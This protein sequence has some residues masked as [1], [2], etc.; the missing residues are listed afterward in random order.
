MESVQKKSFNVFNLIEGTESATMKGISSCRLLLIVST[1]FVV[2]VLGMTAG[3]IF[4]ATNK[5]TSEEVTNQNEGATKE[6]KCNYS[7]TSP[8]THTCPP[9]RECITTCPKTTCPTMSTLVPVAACPDGW[10][11]YSG[12]CY[13]F[14]KTGGSFTEARHYC[15][16]R[17]AYVVYIS[18]VNEDLFIKDQLLERTGRRWWVGITDEHIEGV[19]KS[20]NNVEPETEYRGWSSGEPNDLRGEDC[21]TLVSTNNFQ[22]NDDDCQTTHFPICEKRQNNTT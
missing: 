3:L 16:Q 14:G 10:M 22:W 5:G 13:Y 1:V 11:P 4:V 8:S 15:S 20:V 7:T 19:W 21:V 17:E 18:D 12:S 6:C 9:Q 2:I